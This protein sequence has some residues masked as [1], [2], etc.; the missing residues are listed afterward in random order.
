MAK[1]PTRS[2]LDLQDVGLRSYSTSSAARSVSHDVRF[3]SYPAGNSYGIVNDDSKVLVMD[4]AFARKHDAIPS[5]L[6]GS[7]IGNSGFLVERKV[8]APMFAA[9]QAISGIVDAIKGMRADQ[10][11]PFS[12]LD[13][14]APTRS[15]PA[16]G[17]HLTIGLGRPLPS[18][19][20]KGEH[21]RKGDLQGSGL[22][23]KGYVH[24]YP[25]IPAN[26]NLKMA[27]GPPVKSWKS[28]VSIPVK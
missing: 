12:D 20:K 5:P 16:M 4:D 8:T 24:H 22:A 1:W 7:L 9:A 26:T 6:S 28:V 3:R 27:N 25:D 15:S 2:G 17:A 19:G 21:E 11:A 13:V 18:S 14:S 10:D 23:G